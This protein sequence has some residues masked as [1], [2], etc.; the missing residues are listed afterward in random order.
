MDWILGFFKRK[1]AWACENKLAWWNVAL[2]LGTAAL[3]WIWPGPTSS[4]GPSDFRIRLWGMFLQL[5]GAYTVWHDL[6]GTAREFG[7]NGILV[8]N[9]RWLKRGLG[10]K[11][12]VP[13]YAEFPIRFAVKGHRAKTRV[14]A[15][16]SSPVEQR[17][18]ALEACFVHMDNDIDE[19]FALIETKE[20]EHR[21]ALEAATAD[22]KKSLG[23][24]EKRITNALV[25]NYSML[26][27]GAFWLFVGIVLASTAPEI[28]RAAAGRW[29]DIAL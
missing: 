18:A 10:I 20:R 5:L 6:T 7:A 3:I 9:W 23:D 25:G 22:L 4:S 19:A 8:R 12:Y 26:V 15:D 11:T 16:Q 28:A 27:F 17:L 13:V 24:S 2:V 21:T 29:T 14:T 1:W